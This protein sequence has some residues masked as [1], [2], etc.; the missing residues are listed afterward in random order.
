MKFLTSGKV[1]DVYE[2]TNDKLLFRFT[3]RISAFDVQFDD[4]IPH[5]GKILCKFSKFWFEHIDYPNHFITIKS[6]RE[7]IVKKLKMLPV[8][9]IV[10]GYFYGSIVERY[11]NNLIKIKQ[12]ELPLASKL[13]KPIFD[14]TTKAMHDLPINKNDLAEQNSIPVTM[15]NNLS[16]ISIKIYEQMSKI[17][18]SSGFILADL[19]LEFGLLED[20][21][22]LADSIGPDECR[23]WSKKSYKEGFIQD[24]FDKQILRDWLILHNYKQK[25]E[26][27]R[28]K[29]I[30]PI[31]P[32]LPI[33]LISKISNRY[34]YIYNKIVNK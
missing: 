34:I 22:I 13:N 33:D 10:R 18:D 1:K 9:C 5:K 16:R 7:I 14:P 28:Q 19:K 31:A 24:S 2:I 20:K 6:N 4:L 29:M 27:A 30:T 26:S 15:F 3:D 17:I 11:K 23:L 32:K 21:I 12:S 25:F 8:E